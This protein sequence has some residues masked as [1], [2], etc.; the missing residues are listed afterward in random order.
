LSHIKALIID[1]DDT[2]LDDRTAARKALSAFLAAHQHTNLSAGMRSTE[3]WYKISAAHWLRYEQGKTTFIEQRRA[4]VREFLGM[5]LSDGE[6][7]DAFKPYLAAYEQAWSLVPGCPEFLRRTASIP[8]IIVTNGDREQQLRKIHACGLESHFLTT[9]TPLDCGYWKPHPEMFSL[10]LS[11]LNVIPSECRMIGDDPI[12]DI[13]P[14][15]KLGMDT[16]LVESKHPERNLLNA[17]SA[18]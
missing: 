10:A 1:L 17:I 3:Q 14:A 12:R 11:I 8:K 13:E 7:D 9:I 2:L 16:F 4:R 6:A 15:L 18:I 5:S